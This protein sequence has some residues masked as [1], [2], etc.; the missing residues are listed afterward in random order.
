MM[1]RKSSDLLI[2]LILKIIVKYAQVKFKIDGD[3]PKVEI[4]Q[5]M[6]DTLKLQDK[7]E[8]FYFL[9]IYKVSAFLKEGDIFLNAS[10]T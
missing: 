2:A 6:I 4:I 9:P 7:I 1:F 5:K 3:G 8:F 10:F